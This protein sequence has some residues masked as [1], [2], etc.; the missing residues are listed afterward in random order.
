MTD[1]T[2]TAESVKSW[3]A[4]QPQTIRGK[5][6]LASWMGGAEVMAGE[7]ILNRASIPTYAY[8]DSAARVFTYM[9]QYSYNLRGIYETPVSAEAT[10]WLPDRDLAHQ[11]IETAHQSG[12][13]ILTETE[14]KQMLA[15]YGIPVVDTRIAKNEAEAVELANHI[16]YPVVL[17]LF[18]ET[19]THKT[20]VGGIRLNLPDAD[21][22]RKAYG[23][24]A[25]SV[26][27]K[28]G[29]GY[30]GGVT[31]QPML[32][33]DG[34]EL[35]IGSSTDAQF[36]PV[37]LFGVGGQL[38]EVF[39]DQAVALP[40]LNT[41]LARRLIE[42]TQIYRALQGVRGAKPVD[43]DALEKLLV[44]FSQLVVEHRR[45]KEI[46]INPLLV[47]SGSD[48]KED[49]I[50]SMVAL[51]ARIILHDTELSD[52]QLPKLAIRPY[53][54]QY[55]SPWTMPNGINVVIR[56]IRPEDEPLAVKFHQNLSE[57]SIYLRYFHLV[58][59]S[60]RIAHDRLV[61]LCCMDYDR[62]MALV[63]DHQDEAGNHEL[64]AIARLS[65]LHGVNEAEFAML[66]SD[67]YQRQGLGTELLKRLVQIGKDEGLNRITADILYENAAMQRVAEKAGFRLYRSVDLV[68]AELDL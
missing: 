38:V 41:T 51:D 49:N 59:L 66:V 37:I 36:G 34:S 5:P 11:I 14:S 2:Q 24:I 64:L 67:A 12:R 10:D 25:Q 13:T 58:K 61:R 46:D 45:I 19:I 44:R 55:I 6:I 52:H 63:A 31:V 35:I 4:T 68:R 39:R 32:K 42:Q 17:K 21:T 54:V 16:G 30:F 33:L 18:S 48:N 57:Q 50:P 47:R 9:W 3:I 53:P 60:Q 15:A 7:A 40:P 27:D 62:E 22:V 20:D 43:L 56:P 65:K 1:P 8:P 26:T 29:P 23:G 28:V